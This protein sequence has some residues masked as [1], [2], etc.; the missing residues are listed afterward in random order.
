[1]D[2]GWILVRLPSMWFHVRA[3]TVWSIL[4]HGLPHKIHNQKY[5]PKSIINAMPLSLWPYLGPHEVHIKF[6]SESSNRSHHLHNLQFSIQSNTPT[7]TNINLC[8]PKCVPIWEGLFQCFIPG[9]YIGNFMNW[10]PIKYMMEIVLFHESLSR[11]E[12]TGKRSGKRSG[13]QLIIAAIS[14]KRGCDSVEWGWALS[15]SNRLMR[16]R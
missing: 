2:F 14:R 11:R 6:R 3:V 1:M 10:I 12:R 15:S 4:D 8:P 16:F 5:H 7:P 9:M 13:Y